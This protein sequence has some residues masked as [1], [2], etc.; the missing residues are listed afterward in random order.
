MKTDDGHD[1]E[2]DGGHDDG[3][4]YEE[5]DDGISPRMIY[6]MVWLKHYSERM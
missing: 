6:R 5:E 2:S 4:D 3:E 1:D